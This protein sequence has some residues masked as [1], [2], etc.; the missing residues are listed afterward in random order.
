MGLFQEI[1]ETP[2][3]VRA[4]KFMAAFF[5]DAPLYVID[6]MHVSVGRDALAEGLRSV[7]DK[8]GL[9]PELLMQTLMEKAMTSDA[10]AERVARQIMGFASHWHA[11]RLA[12]ELVRE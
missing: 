4:G 8:S 6:V 2:E 7:G 12:L 11:N 9:D 10:V 1:R 3:R 5:Q